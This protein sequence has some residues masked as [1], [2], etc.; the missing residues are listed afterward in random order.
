[1]DDPYADR[2]WLRFYPE[3][4][5]RD[6][7]VPDVPVTRLLD[8]A[9]AAFPRRRAV[10]YLGRSLTYEQ[11]R[12]EVGRFAR[13]LAALGVH[14]GDRV[15]II[16]PNCP[17]N[18]IA[19]FATLRLG[20]VAV[21]FNPLYTERELRHQLADSGATVA[22]VYDG[23][24]A[25]VAAVR[26]DT[27]LTQVVVTSLVDYLPAT[28]KW[29]LRLP[30][31]RAREKRDRLVTPLPPDHDAEDFCSLL[32]A[33]TEHAE[34][35]QLEPGRDLAALQYTGGTTGL[36]KGAMLTH[37]NLVANA[38]QTRAWDP[39]IVEGKETT[40]G[41]L[42]LFHV[43]GLTL[44]LM[45]TM[46]AAGTLVLLPTFDLD[47]V[48]SAV[49]KEK[50]SIFP[51]VPPM[52]SQV[53]DSPRTADHNLRSIRT[54][55]SGAMRL[56]PSTADRFQEITGGRLVEGYGL[57][58]TAPVAL[59]NPL[60]RNARAGT[61]GLPLPS[62]DARVVD[63]NDP[64][65]V[66]QPGTA[67]ELA[68]RGP[69][70]FS[71]YWGHVG[72]SIAML[73][74]GWILTGDVVTMGP[75]GFFT[76]IDRKRDVILASGFSIFPSE[77]EDAVCE[78]PDVAE[79]VVIGVPDDYRGET[80]K[81]CVVPRPGM[82]LVAEQVQDHCAQLLSAYKVPKLVE[83]RDELPRNIIGKPLRR[84]LREEHA[85]RASH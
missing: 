40:L 38:Y 17:Q 65:V 8:D 45:T 32:E 47:M 42:P 6:I 28:K 44:G 22:V 9:A 80:V 57:T 46:L 29:L 25:R 68:L 52:Y 85:A 53:N 20:A 30:L 48:L 73:H 55:V 59:C 36:P 13:A 70:V 43:Y 79:C 76:I 16:L 66:L 58:E 56:P 63:E 50:P 23:A 21:Q 24:Y 1:M 27:A 7:H 60:N 54:C 41:V 74:K 37:R 61:V 49:S 31:A 67:G 83:M 39:G 19:F 77:V 69:Q 5:P 62:T 82:W 72:D 14:R 2:P 11:L 78:H 12:D 35:A 3:G 15:A 18:V 64:E 34:Q 33:S 75:D 4:V 10:S 26:A 71:G 51:G 84:V 81:A